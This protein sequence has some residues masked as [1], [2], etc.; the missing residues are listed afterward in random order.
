MAIAAMVSPGMP[1]R[2]DGTQPDA[3]LALLLPD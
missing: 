1:N 3:M 2:S